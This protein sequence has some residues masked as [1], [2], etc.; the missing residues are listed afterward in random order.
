[1]NNLS[2]IVASTQNGVIGRDNSLPFRLKDDMKHFVQATLGKNVIMGRKTFE[3]IVSA[4]G[5]ISFMIR[6]LFGR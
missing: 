2:L 4:L 3:S 1:M 5:F 6:Y